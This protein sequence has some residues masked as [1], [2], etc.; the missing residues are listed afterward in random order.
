MISSGF[1]DDL[2]PANEATRFYNRTRA[3]Y[4]NTPLGLF[5][6]DF[7][8]PR[9]ANK[10]DVRAALMARENAWV[11]Y[12]LAGTGTQPASD[13]VTYTQTCPSSSGTLS[14][15]PYTSSDW[16]SQ[17]PGEIVVE[18]GPTQTI[19]AA[20][21]DPLVATAWNPGQ[22]SAPKPCVTA[23]GAEEPGTANYETAPASAAGYTIMGSPTVIA[24]IAQAG[25]NSQIAARL[26]DASADGTT[27]VLI[28]RAL[29]RPA[30]SGYQVFQ[31]N[32]N[33][34]KVEEGHV[35][36]LELLSKDAGGAF[37]APLSNYGRPSNDQQPATI[38]N[39]ELRLPVVESPGALNGLV[40]TPAKKV[41]PNGEGVELARGY[42]AYGSETALEYGKV[43]DPCP[44]GT[45]GSSPPDCTRN[46]IGNL[47]P[48]GSPTV[49]GKTMTIKVTCKVGNDSCKKA[50]IVVQAAGKVRGLKK[51]VLAK[52]K[53]IKATPGQ[54]KKLQ[55]KLT[56]KARKLFKDSRKRGKKVKGIKKVRAIVKINGKR[57]GAKTVRKVGKVR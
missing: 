7:G 57:A 11:D 22:L 26:V 37:A 2:F 52:G 53:G 10:A 25:D 1:T 44:A 54:T 30:N 40:K 31:L 32:P 17:S 15:G 45:H 50:S 3:E 9:A 38:E 29:W 48:V 46:V 21:G 33:G 35:V 27:K 49:K 36:R 13:V 28:N 6:G 12:Y 14:G 18:G 23:A 4:P 39:L 51:P 16:A 8:H 34:W 43:K 5:F 42:E 20:S 19:D 56:A 24:K 55:L 41:L 47:K